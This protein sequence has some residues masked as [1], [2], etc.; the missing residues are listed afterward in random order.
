MRRRRRGR[1]LRIGWILLAVLVL[2]GGYVIWRPAI[3]PEMGATRGVPFESERIERGAQL[4]AIGNCNVCHTREGGIAYAG[5]R[6]IPTPFGTVFT[7]NITPDPGTGI[8]SWTPAAFTRAMREGVSRD[9]RH[10]YP[11]FPYDHMTRMRQLDID[12]VYAFLMTRRPAVATPPDNDLP[13]PF[14]LRPLVAFWKLL[15]LDK[16]AA[17]ED[18]RRG[19]EW[20]R[21]AYLVEGLGHCGAC[22]TPRNALGAEDS[23][24]AYGGGETEGWTAPA[25]NADSPAAVPWDAERLYRYLRHGYDDR[26]GMAAGPMAPVVR[27]LSLV[28]DAEVRAMS[29]YVAAMAGAPNAAR[30]QAASQALARVN[31]DGAVRRAPDTSAGGTIYAG[32]CAQCHGEAGRAPSNPALHLA[33]SSA[34]RT[35]RS[36]NIVRLIRDGVH[37]PD[38]GGEPLMPGFA[39]VLSDAQVVALAAYLRT[40][41]TEQPAWSDIGKSVQRARESD[42]EK[43][44]AQQKASLP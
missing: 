11:A 30:T 41:F 26:H 14:N 42:A 6:P 8:G 40:A 33:L 10:L 39:N 20:N 36:D 23:R 29:V 31:G 38:L 44:R 1:R 43:L 19:P 22:H 12:A 32:A 5:G 15:F 4:A 16:G 35:P 18:S 28:P 27:N 34:L 7:S 37:S 3:A 13:F 25:L 21:G 9:G 24:R 17:A 2:A